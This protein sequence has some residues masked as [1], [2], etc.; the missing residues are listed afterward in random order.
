MDVQEE[1]PTEDSSYKKFGQLLSLCVIPDSSKCAK[2]GNNVPDVVF[3]VTLEKVF[4]H[5]ISVERFEGFDSTLAR[6]SPS[7]ASHDTQPMCPIWY[8]T[9]YK[10]SGSQPWGRMTRW[11]WNNPYWHACIRL[12]LY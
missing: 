6:R 11:P 9:M 10:K 1:R 8:T 4:I 3:D 12:S 2:Q 5:S 7:F